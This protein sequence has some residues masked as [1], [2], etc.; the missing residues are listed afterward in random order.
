LLF[1]IIKK[2]ESGKKPYGLL[3]ILVTNEPLKG[4]SVLLTYPEEDMWEA[5]QK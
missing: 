3:A 1:F 5:A 2:E 4:L